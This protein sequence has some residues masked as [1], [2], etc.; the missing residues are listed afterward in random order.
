MPRRLTTVR[1]RFASIRNR[2]TL[3][4]AAAAP[5]G[6]GRVCRLDHRLDRGDSPSAEIGV[7]LLW[8]FLSASEKPRLRRRHRRLRS[9]LDID[10]KM[11]EPYVNRSLA[12]LQKKEYDAALADA[13]RALEINPKSPEAFTA[14]GWALLVKGRI[15]EANS[16]DLAQAIQLDPK[17]AEAYC[18]GAG[19]TLLMKGK[20]RE[21][22]KESTDALQLDPNHAEAHVVH[23][24]CPP[25]R[26]AI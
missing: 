3:S 23:R 7:R 4:V 5:A 1:R 20:V 8:A 21:A 10:P 24:E 14:R 15:D 22:I 6:E 19:Q 18:D 2:L 12:H 25:E 17:L 11:F 26:S 16:Q 9:R 13:R